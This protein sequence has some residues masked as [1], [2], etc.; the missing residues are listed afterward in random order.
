VGL[1]DFRDGDD[2]DFMSHGAHSSD[3]EALFG[4]L[5]SPHVTARIMQVEQIAHEVEPMASAGKLDIA[6]PLHLVAL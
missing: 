5:A 3:F 6:L 2:L 1:V 4:S